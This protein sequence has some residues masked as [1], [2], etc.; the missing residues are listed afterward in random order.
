MFDALPPELSERI[1]KEATTASPG[2]QWALRSTCRSLSTMPFARNAPCIAH[3]SDGP[4]GLM[5]THRRLWPSKAT[6]GGFP[7]YYYAGCDP[8]QQTHTAGWRHPDVFTTTPFRFETQVVIAMDWKT[9]IWSLLHT[10][11]EAESGLRD[12]SLSERPFVSILSHEEEFERS[13]D[14]PSVRNEVCAVLHD[15][16]T[17]RGVDITGAAAPQRRVHAYEPRLHPTIG[18]HIYASLIDLVSSTG[19][20]HYTVL[21]YA[22]VTYIPPPHTTPTGGRQSKKYRTLSLLSV[23]VFRNLD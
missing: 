17:L 20:R 8:F 2:S 18:G 12:L 22:E 9:V 3:Q 6:Q 19:E 23:V 14:F 21:F 13:T 4:H 15:G 11:V 10:D 1:V 7:V 5:H 16:Q